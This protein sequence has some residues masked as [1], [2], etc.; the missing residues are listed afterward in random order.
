MFA[1]ADARVNLGTL[2]TRYVTYDKHSVRPN[3]RLCNMLTVESYTVIYAANSH[4][5]YISFSS[6]THA[7]IP[8]LKP[9]FSANPS[10]C[11]LSFSSSA[12][13]T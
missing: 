6:P 3:L 12:L 8:G 11:S 9:S 4:T 1:E 2:Y 7:F 10:Y 13:T 5:Y